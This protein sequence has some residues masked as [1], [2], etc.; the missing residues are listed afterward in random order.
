ME[1]K[2][3]KVTVIVYA[4]CILLLAAFFTIS[5]TVSRFATSKSE[6]VA[7]SD[8]DFDAWFEWTT[9]D[10]ANTEVPVLNSTGV[11]RLNNIDD[12][13]NLKL[14]IKYKG[15]G[16]S[17]LR[18]KITESWQHNDGVH[19]VI[20]PHSLST[21]TLGENFYDNRSDD[22]F[23]YYALPLNGEDNTTTL[24]L[25]AITQC[26]G[27]EDA[28]DLLDHTDASTFVDISVELE[29]VQWNRAKELWGISKLPW[30]V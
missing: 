23:I 2:R 12:Y 13:D 5:G 26:I 14:D 9:V 18:F 24:T 25:N 16:R 8:N 10:G 6:T 11:Y 21:Y 17:Y 15:E 29:A 28:L 1:K 19:D 7:A 30:E 4:V 3:F 27:G 22:G 20:T